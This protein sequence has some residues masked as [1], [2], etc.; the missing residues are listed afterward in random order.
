MHTN[1]L[2]MT[3]ALAS[4]IA[5][6]GRLA[7]M[8]RTHAS[9][10]ADLAPRM[11]AARM[12]ARPAVDLARDSL[13]QARIQDAVADSLAE[14]LKGMVGSGDWPAFFAAHADQL[15][16]NLTHFYGIEIES[17]AT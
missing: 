1:D 14:T 2:I 16:S 15:P 10:W 5:M 7:A 8:H 9:E 4:R 13:E 3:R 12:M 17:A 6:A 11:A